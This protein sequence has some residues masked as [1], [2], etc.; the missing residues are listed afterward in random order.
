MF[1]A[2][3]GAILFVSSRRSHHISPFT[4]FTSH[5]SIADGLR[6]QQG[7]DNG[8][9]G[10][11]LGET[12]F[13]CDYGGVVVTKG[14]TSCALSTSKQS[15]GSGIGSAGIM[16]GC[17]AAVY[18]NKILGRKLGLTVTAVVSLIGVI[19]EMT[20]AVGDTARFDQFVVGKIINSIAMGLA[21][22]IIP[23]YL[24]ETSVTSARG[25]VINM[26]QTIQIVGVIVAA[27]S[28]FAVS[29]RLD[30]SAYLIPMG[31]QAIPAGLMLLVGPFLVESPR[32]LVWKG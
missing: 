23:V 22:N 17:A 27:G 6:R 21:A 31:I 12:A 13:L 19:I 26:Y 11:V 8:W 25:F 29:T 18:V 7:F 5:L 10:T 30:K 14:V 1:L 3:I 24:S 28:V 32:W 16:V 20:S 4:L 9:W 15:L 2:S